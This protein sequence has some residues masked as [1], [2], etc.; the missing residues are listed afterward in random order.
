[1]SPAIP[2]IRIHPFLLLVTLT[3]ALASRQLKYDVQNAARRGRLTVSH[4][5][6]EPDVLGSLN[7]RFVQT[8]SQPM[9]N[10]EDIDRS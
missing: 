8:V 10:S 3:Y 9:H 7:R 4:G 1:M 6:L 5:R 2:H